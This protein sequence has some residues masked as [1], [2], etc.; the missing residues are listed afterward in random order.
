MNPPPGG[1]TSPQQA[2]FESW[3]H[4]TQAL[5]AA[6]IQGQAE[7]YRRGRDGP[8]RTMGAMYNFRLGGGYASFNVTLTLQILAIKLARTVGVKIVTLARSSP[9]GTALRSDGFLSPP[10]RVDLVLRK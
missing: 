4:A 10:S 2:V 5:Q 9:K 8:A 6:C 7:Y 3:I 1:W